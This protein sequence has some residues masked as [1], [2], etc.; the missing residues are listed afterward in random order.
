MITPVQTTGKTPSGWVNR[1]AASS[2]YPEVAGPR[3]AERRRKPQ[4]FSFPVQQK[5]PFRQLADEVLGSLPVPGGRREISGSSI[6]GASPGVDPGIG[7]AGRAK[8]LG[9]YRTAV[10]LPHVELPA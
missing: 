9:I 4:G 10:L 3:V 8:D 1:R 7:G 2:G 5:I 6:N